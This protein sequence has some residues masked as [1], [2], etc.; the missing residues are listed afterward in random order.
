M[1][2]IY[3]IK[4]ESSIDEEDSYKIGITKKDPQK[5]LKQLQTGSK[6]QLEL[7]YYYNSSIPNLLESTLHRQF[8]QYRTREKGE[9]FNLPIDEVNKFLETCKNT[10]NLLIQVKNQLD[11]YK[12]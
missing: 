9:W 8:E 5:R 11:S 3:L 2:N 10:E 7:L 1:K 4:S 12:I 6:E